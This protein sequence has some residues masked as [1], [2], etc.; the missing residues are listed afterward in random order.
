MRVFFFLLFSVAACC[1]GQQNKNTLIANRDKLYKNIVSNT[2]NKNL[3]ETLSSYTQN[4][5]QA[6]FYAIT[7]LH[8]KN[9][10]IDGKI[11]FA[12]KKISFYENSFA[13]AL[14]DVLYASYK[15]KYLP[16][17]RFFLQKQNDPKLFAMA[18]NYLLLSKNRADT[19][20]IKKNLLKLIFADAD[21]AILKQLAYSLVHKNKVL[22][23]TSLLP[24]FKKDYLPGNTLLFSF[25]NKNRDLPGFVVVR[26]TAGNFIKNNDSSIFFVPQLARSVSGMPAYISNGNT[27]QGIF[28][29]DGFDTSKSLFIGPTTNIQLTMPFEGTAAHFFKDSLIST[30]DSVTYR[31]LL[32]ASLKDYYPIYGTFFAGKAGRTEIIAHGTTVDP[33]WYKGTTY[34]PLT[35][36]AGCL[37]TKE[38]WSGSTGML[39]ESDQQKLIDAVKKAGGPFG[40]LIVTEVEKNSKPIKPA[41]IETIMR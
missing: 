31:K 40:Y 2:I 38:I 13:Q 7:L 30:W 5:W 41:D 22:T 25:Q 16:E 27:A 14:L 17:I 33:D 34:Y 18:A 11:S 12:V 21:N 8:Y 6:A 23:I 20:L 28:R 19:V 9:V 1:F 29:M 3:D 26:D 15:G 35:P 32:P 10:F 4:N 36:T 37:C 39:I 24:F